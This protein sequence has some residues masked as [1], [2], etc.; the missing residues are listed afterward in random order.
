MKSSGAVSPAARATASI[1]PVRMPGIAVGKQHHPHGL[2]G[3]RAHADRRLAHLRRHH[4]DRVFGRQHD[5]R[6]HQD[7]QRDRARQR[8]ETARRR[9]RPRRTR[10]RR[11]GSRE[12]RSAPWRRSARACASLSFGFGLRQKDR[13]P[14]RRA[15][16]VISAAT[17]TIT[18]RADDG[19]A[20][21]AARFE[22]RGRQL[23]EARPSSSACRRARPA[24]TARRTAGSAR[25]AVIAAD[26]PAQQR[27][28]Q[29]CA[30]DAASARARCRSTPRNG[31]RLAWAIGA[32]SADSDRSLRASAVPS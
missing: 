24:S 26:D 30:A 1:T 29:A 23:G 9:A 11:P 13:A 2:R 22:R 32:V 27:V 3:R 7:R 17:P 14:G 10:T 5:G 8:G 15:G 4:A 18:K 21:A 31:S 28:E 6:Q 12:S 16:S 25:S 19:V 20:E